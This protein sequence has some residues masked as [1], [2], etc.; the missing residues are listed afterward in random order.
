MALVKRMSF[1]PFVLYRLCLGVFLGL[2]VGIVGW[3]WQHNI[4]LGIIIGVAMLLNMTAAAVAGVVVPLGLR[5]FGVDPALASAI[6]VTTVTD[7]AGFFFFL[8]LATLFLKY[9]Q[10]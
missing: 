3:I 7:C 9:I 10:P 4:A 6:F 2:G 1:A 8:G 5:L